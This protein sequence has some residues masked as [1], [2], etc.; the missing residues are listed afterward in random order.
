[1]RMKRSFVWAIAV[2]CVTTA[3]NSPG[4]SAN[5]VQPLSLPS[6]AAPAGRAT[7]AS[8]GSPQTSNDS[9]SLCTSEPCP[10]G[11]DAGPPPESSC[12]MVTNGIDVVVRGSRQ[13]NGAVL[14]S[15]VGQVPPGTQPAPEGDGPVTAPPGTGDSFMVVRGDALGRVGNVQGGCPNLTFTV[16]G[17]PV[18]TNIS[19]KYF[20]LPSPPPPRP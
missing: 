7:P 5:P 14:A 4:N 13:S 3:C 8:Y 10:G 11:V 19:T 15:E 12:S 20:G 16:A 2:A 6:A 17:T 9:P 1:M 18:S